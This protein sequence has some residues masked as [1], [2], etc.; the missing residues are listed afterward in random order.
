MRAGP[1]SM[2]RPQRS[3]REDW[4]VR[5]LKLLARLDLCRDASKDEDRLRAIQDSWLCNLVRNAH[6]NCL[7]YRRRFDR[8][9]IEAF[10]GTKDL[11]SLPLLTRSEL[12]DN[13]EGIAAKGQGDFSDC[14]DYSTSGST[15]QPVTVLRS[16]SAVLLD[17]GL[18]RLLA[19]RFAISLTLAPTRSSLIFVQQDTWSLEERMPLLGMG[20]FYRFPLGSPT[21]DS[22]EHLFAFL[23]ANDGVILSSSPQSLTQLMDLYEQHDGPP[24]RP[25]VVL[26]SGSHIS[27]AIRR[28]ATERFQA[29]VVNLYATVEAGIV[30]MQCPRGDALH[31]ESTSIVECLGPEGRPVAPGTL[32]ELVITDLRNPKFPIVRYRNGDFGV[33]G[34]GRCA[35]GSVLPRIESLSGRTNTVFTTRSGT[36]IVPATM[37]RELRNLPV[38]QYQVEQRDVDDFVLRYRP[39]TQP[40][41]NATEE[42][43]RSIALRCL[44]ERFGQVHL[45]IEPLERFP[46]T[47]V[48]GFVR[49]QAPN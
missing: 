45:R 22:P 10:E 4:N 24:M 1:H 17:T 19:E 29:P 12:R 31:V 46:G 28:R 42:H 20:R 37:N 11:S 8:A 6:R 26:S 2:V 7:Y 35:C 44:Q 39:L 21:W 48:Q 15:G 32:G 43:I 3:Y 36:T 9:Q 5:R 27:D 13:L 49:T 14:G 18:L 40:S 33:L 47:K 30:A 25:A 16:R 34:T 23:A 38:Y 41:P